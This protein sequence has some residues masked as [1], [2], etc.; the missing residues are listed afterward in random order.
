[1]TYQLWESD[2]ANLVGSYETEDDA[3][4]I[5]RKAVETHGRGTVRSLVLIREDPQGRLTDVAGG[6]T[7]ADLA[8]ARSMP[9]S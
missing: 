6:D 1:M 7:L 4:L 9:I 5:V 2:S 8:L 3:L